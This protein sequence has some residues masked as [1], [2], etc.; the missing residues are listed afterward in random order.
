MNRNGVRRIRDIKYH[1]SH[2]NNLLQAVDMASRA[3]N[4]RYARNHPEF[5]HIIRSRVVDI[6]FYP[7]E[8]LSYPGA[9]P[10]RH[11]GRQLFAQGPF[12]CTRIAGNDGMKDRRVVDE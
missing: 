6:W 7:E 5:L 1:E 3:I 4:A 8:T 11:H 12:A 9:C 10:E 2:R